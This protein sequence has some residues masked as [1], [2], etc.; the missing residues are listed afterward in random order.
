MMGEATKDTGGSYASIIGLALHYEVHGSGRPLVLL[1]G[2]LSATGASF[3]KV[4]PSFAETRQVVAVEQSPGDT[5]ELLQQL[6][7]EEADLSID[8]LIRDI[9]EP[10]ANRHRFRIVQSL[11]ADT[12]TFSA[13]S[14]LTGL[15]GGNL[16]FHLKKL[17]DVGII[18]QRHE[19][20][21][22]IITE[23]GYKT[24]KGIGTLYATLQP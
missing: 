10:L 24:L 12:Q 8:I 2:A 15:L 9:L 13:L 14:S 3:G 5:A 16:L 22:Y 17:Q 7:I 1:H 20:G 18:L 4:L 21:D 23:K 19:R 6:G 11:A